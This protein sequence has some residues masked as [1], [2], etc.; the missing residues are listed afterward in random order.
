MPPSNSTKPL[1]HA[2]AIHVTQQLQF[3]K[4]QVQQQLELDESRLH[5][6]TNISHE[7]RTP[8]TLITGPLETIITKLTDGVLKDQAQLAKRNADRLLQLVNQLLDLRKLQA[9]KLQLQLTDDDIIRFIKGIVTSLQSAAEQK[10]LNLLFASSV[11]HL[12][13]SFDPDK[14]EKVLVNVVSNAIKFT[15]KQGCITV[16]AEPSNAQIQL[17]VEDNGVGIPTHQLE[18]VFER[19]YRV[20][21][22]GQ[23]TG[24][25]IG[26]SLARELTQ[27]HGGT[28]AV[29]SPVQLH[30]PTRPGTRFTIRLPLH[31]PNVALPAHTHSHQQDDAVDSEAA[32]TVLLVED[33]EDM[34]YYIGTILTNEYQIQEAD[35]GRK[36]LELARR[37]LPDLIISDVMMPEMDG[38]EFCRTLKYDENTSHIPVI[39]LTAKGSEAAQVEGLETGADDYVVKPFSQAVLLARIANLLESRR[40]LQDRFQK[41]LVVQ[42]QTITS[43][44]VD[45]RFLNRALE[46][47]ET[48][49]ADYE[50]D[51]DIFATCMHMSRSTLYR[52]TKALTGQS[53][54]LFIRSVRL[55]HAAVLLKTGQYNVSEVAYQVGF[56]DMSYFGACFKEQFH[57][58]PSQYMADQSNK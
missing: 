43:N 29:E 11:P 26:L 10:Q 34:R 3:E 28:I 53:P 31:L 17:T 7:L 1:A 8:L 19:F 47:V 35:N 9:G 6:F 33:N 49:Q 36:G 32:P 16:T 46:I 51:V 50:F 5:F 57:C 20:D 25:G 38:I 37:H 42:P 22:H 13:T 55:K 54:S 18:R 41:D 23:T 21:D 56:L 14:L 27:L 45:E 48:H 40:R 15:P 44:P 30:D 58:S 39:L 4:H 24:S 12:T 52:K 2:H